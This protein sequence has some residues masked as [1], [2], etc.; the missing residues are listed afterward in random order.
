MIPAACYRDTFEKLEEVTTAQA[1]PFL[2]FGHLRALDEPIRSEFFERYVDLFRSLRNLIR[3]VNF[4]DKA[5]TF[6]VRPFF[7]GLF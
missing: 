3:P 2:G 5:A 6:Y 4:S 7:V 1:T